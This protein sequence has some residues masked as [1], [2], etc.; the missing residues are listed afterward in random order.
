MLRVGNWDRYLV[1]AALFSGVVGGVVSTAKTDD[2]FRGSD[3]HREIAERD[4]RIE[5][6]EVE[7]KSHLLHSARYTEIIEGERREIARLRMIIERHHP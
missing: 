1:I 6:L 2:R 4:A 7:L 5:R 3:F